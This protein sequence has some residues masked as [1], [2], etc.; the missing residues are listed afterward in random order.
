QRLIGGDAASP[1]GLRVLQ[2]G[3]VT[4]MLAPWSARELVRGVAESVSAGWHPERVTID[5][6]R[7]ENQGVVVVPGPGSHGDLAVEIRHV[8]D[9]FVADGGG[10]LWESARRLFSG[11]RSEPKRWSL[12]LG[13]ELVEYQQGRQLWWDISFDDVNKL[14]D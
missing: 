6:A 14:D 9:R 11:G 7:L 3:G 12:P 10:S 13:C 4:L 5:G 8:L 1:V 2:T